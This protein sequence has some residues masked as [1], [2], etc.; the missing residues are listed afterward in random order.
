MN[1]Y[2]KIF[3]KLISDYANKFSGYNKNRLTPLLYNHQMSMDFNINLY[4]KREDTIDNIGSG[5]KY[6]KISYII[7]DAVS[8]KSTVLVTTG[9]VAS[10][11]CKA[12][13]YFAAA[14]QLKAHV[15]YGGD[16]QKK[17]H[18]AQGNYLLTSLFNPS[19]TWFEESKWE[20]IS[21]KMDEIV[22]A[23][24][25]RGESVY[26]I[27]SGASEWPG[28]VGSIELGFELAGQCFE[29]NID[30]EV[31]IVLPFGSGGTCLGLHVAADIL[32]LSWNIYGMCIGDEPDI[33]MK[34]LENMKFDL[35]KR[36]PFLSNNI[37]NVFLL[38]L[39]SNGKY[40]EP[41]KIELDAMQKA[42]QNYALLLDTNYMIK[43][44]LGL[45]FLTSLDQSTRKKVTILLH[46]GGSIGIFNLNNNMM[47]WH[48]NQF[49]DWVV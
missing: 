35:L 10:N 3:N 47:N 1:Y 8:K 14:N 17:P 38:K 42:L 30:G 13:S 36:I 19:V 27:N 18:H 24:L 49:K 5:N 33:G 39:P 37:Q 20:D 7:D 12:V 34:R 25:D 31:N 6:R 4:I 16:T 43:A 46:T 44:Y 41:S 9:S 15:V 22:D 21:N 45:N 2:L 48:A 26:R 23:L 40:D 29:N 28:I 11:Q 32:G